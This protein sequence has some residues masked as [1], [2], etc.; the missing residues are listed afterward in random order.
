MIMRRAVEAFGADY[1]QWRAL[2]RTMLKCDFRSASGIQMGGAES[3]GGNRA[4]WFSLI[5]YALIGLYVAA[6]VGA[7]AWVSGTDSAEIVHRGTLLGG[8]VGMALVATMLGMAILIDFQTVVISPDDYDIL[9]H[10]P[11]SS[12]TYF[13]VKL[14][15]VMVY[16]MIIGG[17]VGVPAFFPVLVLSGLTAAAGWLLGVVGVILATTLAI[18]CGYAA[19]LRFVHPQ[20]LKRVI[21]YIHVIFFMAVVGAPVLLGEVLEPIFDR[22]ELQGGFP[23][24]DWLLLIPPAWFAS[25]QSLFGGEWSA[26]L[27]VAALAALGTVALLLY[28]ASARLSFSYAERLGLMATASEGRRRS[29][30]PR[31]GHRRFSP[32]F[33]AV[34]AL[35]RGQFRD[36]MTFRLGVLGLVPATILY[37]FMAMRDG[38]LLDPFVHLGF[39]S[40]RLWLLH[41][42]ALGFPLALVETLFKSESFAAA[43]I[44]F[45][46][47]VARDRLV[48]N[49]GICVTTFFI[50]PYALL[51]A[52]IFIW[53]FGNLWHAMAHALV[54]ALM[55]HVCIQMLLLVAPRL[56][57]SQPTKKGGRMGYLM[58]TITVGVVIAAL[59]PLVLWVGYSR[60]GFTLGLLGLLAVAA[61]VMPRMVARGIRSRVERLEFTG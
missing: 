59:L 26:G 44:F 54:L 50:A 8:T 53:S 38:P 47:P 4:F 17:L 32:E 45:T 60:T 6:M 20:R 42:A 37:L 9:A 56:P 7:T 11:I 12:R 41:L 33:N 3:K 51:L 22:A 10:Q 46:A 16:A 19:L 28:Y 61:F 36:D 39:E 25:F 15:N 27:A 52:G 13:L 30:R 35:I 57:F 21:S 49:S 31:P 55:A 34:A 48:V 5:W 29:A 1:P 58:G 23:T 24:P 2:T 40:G 43:W 14:T 18:I